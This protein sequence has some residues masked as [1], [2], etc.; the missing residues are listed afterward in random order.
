MITLLSSRSHGQSV[1]VIEGAPSK[2][3]TC[4]FTEGVQGACLSSFSHSVHV[5]AAVQERGLKANLKTEAMIELLLDSSPL[6]FPSSFLDL[7]LTSAAHTPLAVPRAIAL[8]Q[9]G[10]P[11]DRHQPGR[12]CTRQVL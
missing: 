4:R 2:H 8:Y 11:A 12:A 10:P 7:T 3:E 6:A 9:R 1:C 5:E